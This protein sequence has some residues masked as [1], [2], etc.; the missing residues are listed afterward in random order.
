MDNPE[1]PST[2]CHVTF[3]MT[4][5]R[6]MNVQS[7]GCVAGTLLSEIDEQQGGFSRG[8]AEQQLSSMQQK[9]TAGNKSR[10]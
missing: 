2:M 8:E 7:G 6:R 5:L 1:H 10:A 9:V 4:W 3:W